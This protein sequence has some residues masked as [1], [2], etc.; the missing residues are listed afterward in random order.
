[1]SKITL[2]PN[3][4]GA[5]TFSIQSPDSNS[6]RVL[7]LPDTE[8]TFVSADSNNNLSLD[9]IKLPERADN[10]LNASD[11]TLYY[12][13]SDA[14]PRIQVNGE[15]FDIINLRDGSTPATAARSGK[16][17]LL[18]GIN[19]SGEYYIKPL[20]YNGD[21]ILCYV[22]METDGGGWVLCGVYFNGS[23]FAMSNF[24]GGRDESEV[25]NFP[26]SFP[27][28]S[29]LLNRDFVNALMYQSGDASLTNFS[30][31]S[32]CGT[33]SGGYILANIRMQGDARTSTFDYFKAV[34]STQDLNNNADIKTL[35]DTST[36]SSNDYVGKIITTSYSNYTDGR[37]NLS[38]GF[39]YIPDDTTD[40]G[41]WLFREND[42]DIPATA[43]PGSSNVPSAY[44]IG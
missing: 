34:Y 2:E 37:T 20:G 26:T 5:G 43:Y 4:S 8:G 15:F 17:L 35:T 42:D 9:S 22:D 38:N 19:V 6:N 16:E 10:P 14:R 23:G 25:K 27:N 18:Q 13:T 3:Q 32:I 1:M 21:P 41:Q 28:R 7:T 30:Y 33:S 31:L 44:F 36:N 24:T 39:H 40:G 11:G 29:K 12:N